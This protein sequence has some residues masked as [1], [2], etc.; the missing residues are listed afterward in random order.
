MTAQNTGALIRSLRLKKQMTQKQLADALCVSDKAVSKWERG[1]GLPDISLLA[2]LSWLLGIEPARLLSGEPIENEAR[3]GNMKNIK[4]YICPDCGNL[5]TATGE[6]QVSCCGAR[7]VGREPMKAEGMHILN[8]ETVE[9]EWFITTSHEM[10]KQHHITF[11]AFATGEKLLTVL[12][13]PEWELQLRLPKM[14]H[15]KL[16][17][18]CKQHGVF[19][20]LL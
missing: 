1:A 18:G 17:F 15:G 2:E 3:R 9:D 4:F 16:F 10:S 14:G 19:Y 8:V 5:I 11:A 12:Q 6:A 13:Y 20:Q 7:L